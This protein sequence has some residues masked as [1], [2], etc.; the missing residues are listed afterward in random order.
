M[1]ESRFKLTFIISLVLIA[2]ACSSATTNKNDSFNRSSFLEEVVSVRII[3]ALNSINDASEALEVAIIELSNNP[4]IQ[5]LEVTRVKWIDVYLKWQSVSPFN[6]GPA[7]AN[8]L[9]KTLQEEVATFP[10]SISKIESRISSGAFNLNDFDRD[11]RGL[12]TLEYLLFGSAGTDQEIVNRMTETGFNSFLKAVSGDCVLRLSTVVNAWSMEEMENFVSNNGTDAGS[13]TSIFFNEYIK[14]FEGLKNFKVALPL[15][16]R[17]GQLQTEPERV[18]AYFSGESIRG[19][20]NHVETIQ[21]LWEGPENGIGFKGYLQTVS[22]GAYLIQATQT[23]FDSLNLVLDSIQ[24][25]EILSNLIAN[26]DQRVNDLH[27]ELQKLTR[28]LKSDL[29]SLIGIAITYTSGDGD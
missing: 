28:Y 20:K 11:A 18:E 23:Q 8:G 29:S 26:N 16:L 22:G 6:F 5:Q 19:L 2:S 24:S 9:R 1:S 4:S 12:F 3:P 25:D 14:N 15:G 13:S 21:L 10:V 7:E 17:P 27:T